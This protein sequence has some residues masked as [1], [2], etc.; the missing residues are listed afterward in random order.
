MI[1]SPFNPN[2]PLA[3]SITTLLFVTLI[4]G[5]I[6][7]LIVLGPTLYSYIRFRARPGDD[8][9]P[10]QNLGNTRLEVLWTVTPAVVLA[11]LFGLTL[12]TMRRSD[13]PVPD[14][15][16]PDLIV[17]GHQWWWEFQY[18][19]SGIVTANEIHIPT[20]K[21]LLVQVTS[22]DVIHN[23]WVP[24]LGR[25]VDATPGYT[26][27]IWLEANKPGTYLGACNEYCGTQHAWM[28]IRVIADSPADFAAW[29]QSQ[30]QVPVIPTTGDAAKGSQLFQSLTCSNCHN[31][32]GTAANAHIGPDLTH[33]GSRETLAAGVLNNTPGDL[34]AWLGNPQAIKPGAH[35][36]NLNLTPDEV[37]ALVAYLE[38]LQ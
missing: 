12:L 29:E 7:F 22:A 18:P 14:N 35:M 13:P 26:S 1:S 37:H 5:G 21:R 4:I 8:E 31:I 23:F 24:Q 25:K 9:E 36:P 30:Q 11:A 34:A 33:L 3:S 10:Y 15:A 20:G 2:S 38:S 16:Q 32:D 17:T 19:D 6:V 27:H 28:R